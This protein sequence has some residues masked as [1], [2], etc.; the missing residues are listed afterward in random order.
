MENNARDLSKSFRIL[1]MT[2][3]KYFERAIEKFGIH[4]GQHHILMVL[5]GKKGF[6]TQKEIADCLHITAATVAVAIKKLEKTGYIKKIQDE[7]DLRYNKISLTDKGIDIVAQSRRTFETID[8]S[9]FSDF[10]DD[11]K[12]QMDNYLTRMTKNINKAQED[13]D[14]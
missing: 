7:E 2:H 11:E 9:L 8:S 10:T 12:R 13:K 6:A 3:R 1:N 4:R 14:I 5:S